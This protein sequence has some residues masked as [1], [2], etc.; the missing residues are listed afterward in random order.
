MEI[1]YILD[2]PELCGGVKVVFQHANLLI[3]AGHDVTV[4]AVGKQPEWAAY[5]GKYIDLERAPHPS[6]Q[7]D[8]VVTSF[9]STIAV[10]EQLNLGPI[11]H[12][13]Q[14]YEASYPHLQSQWREIVE[15]YRR[16]YPCFAVSE[17]LSNYLRETYSKQ[18][19]MVP[20]VLD[21]LFIPGPRETPT[22][23][24]K[25]VVSGIYECTWKGVQTALDAYRELLQNGLSCELTRISLIPVNEEERSQV[26]ADNYVCNQPPS[27]IASIMQTSDLLLF[28]S[29]QEEGFGLPL[30]EAMACGV[31]VVA[32]DIPSAR[33]ITLGKL[34]LC[35]VKNPNEFAAQAADILTNDQLW[36]ERS[37]LGLALAQ[38]YQS[39]TVQQTL[40]QAVEWA[41]KCNPT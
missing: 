10:A 34:P 7:F 25:V 28:A 8:L 27:T 18:V 5:Q 16:P 13:C 24:F 32:S 23:P 20:P 1:A 15:A 26:I 17:F 29:Q 22:A 41:Q 40:C 3:E 12:Y 39:A 2:R 6:M 37:T 19:F 21:E 33:Q 35:N 4:F 36:H 11:V 14:G 31:P 38:Q 30:L 9:W